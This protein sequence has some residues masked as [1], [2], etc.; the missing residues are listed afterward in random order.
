MPLPLESTA[1]PRS[2]LIVSAAP[3]VSWCCRGDVLTGAR[4]R[5]GPPDAGLIDVAAVVALVVVRGS[6][7]V[8]HVERSCPARRRQRQPAPPPSSRRRRSAHDCD[9]DDVAR[10]Q[11]PGRRSR[12]AGRVARWADEAGWSFLVL[13]PGVQS[14]SR[15]GQRPLDGAR[16]SVQ[17]GRD[18]VDGHVGVVVQQHRRAHP[19]GEPLDQVAQPGIAGRGGRRGHR[20]SRAQSRRSRC[21]RRHRSRAR[22]VAVT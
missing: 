9:D 10:W 11:A 7:A 19:V 20:S 8:R 5:V 12:A 15:V 16:G 3:G 17:C 4:R 6:E 2:Q 21:S 1:R 22:F 14:A 18:L 13:Q